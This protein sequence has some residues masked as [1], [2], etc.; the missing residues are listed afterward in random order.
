MTDVSIAKDYTMYPGGRFRRH[1]K[2]SGEEFREIY[3]EPTLRDG[4]SVKV[5]MDGV[6]GYPASFLEEAFGG[7]IR[8]GLTYEQIDGLLTIEAQDPSYQVYVDKAWQYISD[9]ARQAKRSS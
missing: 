5:L 3:L 9:E 4:G 6:A 2:G 8:A 1:G 7:L